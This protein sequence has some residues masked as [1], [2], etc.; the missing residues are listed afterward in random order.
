MQAYLPVGR[1][2]NSRTLL[3]YVDWVLLPRLKLCPWETS[4]LRAQGAT[5]ILP[6][7]G[8][9]PEHTLP[10]QTS[11]KPRFHGAF[12]DDLTGPMKS[13]GFSSL[14]LHTDL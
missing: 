14:S 3:L 11:P 1:S 9:T 5:V 10:K 4:K 2:F 8:V 6:D 7:A 13:L 12:S